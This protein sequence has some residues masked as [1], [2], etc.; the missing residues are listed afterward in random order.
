MGGGDGKDALPPLPRQ[1][2]SCFPLQKCGWVVE[3]KAWL[4]EEEVSEWSLEL[5]LIGAK[6]M[7]EV[8]TG[9]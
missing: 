8:G 9:I 7:E 3:D 6:W 5:L 1:G 2:L 4:E